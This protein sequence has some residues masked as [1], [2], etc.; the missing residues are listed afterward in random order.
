MRQ[1]EQALKKFPDW[2]L[3]TRVHAEQFAEQIVGKIIV[4]EQGHWSERDY[5]LKDYRIVS[6][7]IEMDAIGDAEQVIALCEEMEG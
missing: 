3:P 1:I 5:G 7:R 4:V 6:T 2:T